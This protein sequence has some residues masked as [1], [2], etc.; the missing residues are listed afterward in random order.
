[1]Q[2]HLACED[3]EKQE[4]EVEGKLI[5]KKVS[6]LCSSRTRGKKKIHAAVQCGGRV[7]VTYMKLTN[8]LYTL[9]HQEK[10][11]QV[12]VLDWLKKINLILF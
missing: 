7:L 6:F 8:K 10:C 5:E 2:D 1:M 9:K 4:E 3:E 11:K 12:T